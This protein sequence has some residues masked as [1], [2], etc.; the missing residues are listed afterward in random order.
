MNLLM[1]RIGAN[2]TLPIMVIL[3][4]IICAC[5][6]NHFPLACILPQRSLHSLGAVNSYHSLLVCRFFLGAIEGIMRWHELRRY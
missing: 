2:V 6:G 3:W 5:Q 1:K 4:G